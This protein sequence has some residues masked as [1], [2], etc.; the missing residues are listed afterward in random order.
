MP[1]DGNEWN[2]GTERQSLVRSE[3]V[4][5]AVGVKFCLRSNEDEWRLLPEWASLRRME[6]DSLMSP[7]LGRRQGIQPLPLTFVPSM[8]FQHLNGTLATP[9]LGGYQVT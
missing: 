2:S 9:I 6:A 7:C 1:G 4:G 8:L 3:A 5:V